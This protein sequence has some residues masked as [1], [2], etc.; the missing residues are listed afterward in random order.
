VNGFQSRTDFRITARRL[1]FDAYFSLI[2]ASEFPGESTARMLIKIIAN[3]ESL[4]C[5]VDYADE[6][7]S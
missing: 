6:M 5:I 3:R 4:W 1:R 7:I 2:I